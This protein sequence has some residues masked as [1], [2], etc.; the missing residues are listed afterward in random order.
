MFGIEKESL[1]FLHYLQKSGRNKQNQC[2]I[3]ALKNL[4]PKCIL[5]IIRYPENERDSTTIIE[6]SSTWRYT[7]PSSKVYIGID[8]HFFCKY[9]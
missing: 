9:K 5:L 7:I 6:K 1:K 2:K 4:N 8:F 3:A